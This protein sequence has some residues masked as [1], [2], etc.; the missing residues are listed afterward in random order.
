MHFGDRAAR[1]ERAGIVGGERGQAALELAVLAQRRQRGEVTIVA[2]ASA[3]RRRGDAARIVEHELE[4]G[5]AGGAEH[6]RTGI[7][8]EVVAPGLDGVDAVG[9]A[10][11]DLVE[12]VARIG[13]PC[14]ALGDPGHRAATGTERMRAINAIDG[15]GDRSVGSAGIGRDR[16]LIALDEQRPAAARLDGGAAGGVE[17][18]ADIGERAHRFEQPV[19]LVEQGSLRTGALRYAAECGID[20]GE[21]GGQRVELIRHRI[22]RLIE[23]RERAIERRAGRGEAAGKA[24]RGLKHRRARRAGRGIGGERGRRVEEGGEALVELVTGQRALDP[25]EPHHARLAAREIGT[26]AAHLGGAQVAGRAR[27]ARN[28]DAKAVEDAVRSVAGRGDLARAGDA[29][30]IARGAGIGDILRRRG[31][32]GLI[33]ADAAGADREHVGHSGLPSAG[34]AASVTLPALARN[35]V[36]ALP[37][38]IGVC[39]AMFSASF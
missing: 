33:R 20:L 14:C 11:R 36:I 12:R 18:G 16:G 24:G 17:A 10:D 34:G 32:R 26:G 3:R 5:G 22:G 37:I 13:D 35:A 19:A 39:A 9:D 21:A 25:V 38:P 29:A 4:V 30:R 15:E 6:R 2:L 23:I 1:G 31:Q 7:A 8:V 27:D 28:G